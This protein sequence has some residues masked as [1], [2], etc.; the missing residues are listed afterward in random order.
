M[1]MSVSAQSTIGGRVFI[2]NWLVYNNYDQMVAP[3]VENGS[4]E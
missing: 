4:A 3:R 2:E 1:G